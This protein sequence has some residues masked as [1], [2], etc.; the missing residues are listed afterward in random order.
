MAD[1]PATEEAVAAEFAIGGAAASF[2]GQWLCVK[3][4]FEKKDGV[5][6]LRDALGTKAPSDDVLKAVGDETRW[7]TRGDVS[8]ALLSPTGLRVGSVQVFKAAPGEC[9]GRAAKR[10]IAFGTRPRNED[11]SLA[12]VRDQMLAR[13]AGTLGSNGGTAASTATTTTAPPSHCRPA[14]PAPAAPLP[15][16]LPPPPLA[17]GATSTPPETPRSGQGRCSRDDEHHALPPPPSLIAPFGSPKSGALFFSPPPR[18]FLFLHGLPAHS[19]SQI[20]LVL[21]TRDKK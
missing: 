12:N 8:N 3:A 4:G 6:F 7:W 1:V 2:C 16:P 9:H 13:M 20:K 17:A 10:Y 14:R 15:P 18:L 19:S 21:S 5:V 11:G